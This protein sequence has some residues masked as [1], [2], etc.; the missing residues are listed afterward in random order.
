MDPKEYRL[1]LEQLCE[2]RD[3]KPARNAGE[4]VNDES[5]EVVIDGHK[6]VIDQKHNPTLGFDLVK[7]KSQYKICELGCGQIVEN[8]KIERRLCQIP[9][10]HWRTRC[11]SCGCFVSPDGLTMIKGG[12]KI[13][14]AYLNYFYDLKNNKS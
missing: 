6:V 7:L 3:N 13:A 11:S 5:T 10:R 9:Q 4:R 12:A 14:A 1:R 2:L 8:Q